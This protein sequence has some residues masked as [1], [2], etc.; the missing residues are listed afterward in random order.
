MDE[1]KIG[2]LR[3]DYLVFNWFLFAVDK[4]IELVP[5]ADQKVNVVCLFCGRGVLPYVTYL[6]S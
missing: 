1:R 3:I 6:I 4:K 2:V 5:T